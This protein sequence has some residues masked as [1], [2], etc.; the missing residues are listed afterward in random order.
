MTH[1]LHRRS[2][3]RWYAVALAVAV[4][5]MLSGVAAA[6]ESPLVL[7]RQGSFFV[8]GETRTIAPGTDITVNQMYVQYQV[9]VADSMG[10]RPA[11][12]MIHG[13]C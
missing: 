1:E 11:V 10:E 9:P 12:V 4:A 6:D 7:A 3:R 5:L 13:C 8:G 2:M